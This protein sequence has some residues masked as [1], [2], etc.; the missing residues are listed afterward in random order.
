MVP[1]TNLCFSQETLGLIKSMGNFLKLETKI[2]DIKT[3]T[4]AFNLNFNQLE[5]EIQ[6]SGVY[7]FLRLD[8]I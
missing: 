8:Y 2:E 3:I 4:L 6:V 1:S 5:L 7:I